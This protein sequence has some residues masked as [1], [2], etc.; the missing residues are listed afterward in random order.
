MITFFNRLTNN[1]RSILEVPL[2]WKINQKYIEKQIEKSI[3]FVIDIG[4]DVCSMSDANCVHQHI[5]DI[6]DPQQTYG[7]TWFLNI[8][9][10]CVDGVIM[11][12]YIF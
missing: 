1:L 12:F 9:Q 5:A 4:L 8:G 2:A 6:R 3:D 11:I 7:F 10:C